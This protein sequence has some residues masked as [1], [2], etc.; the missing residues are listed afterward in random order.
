MLDT[1]TFESFAG[2]FPEPAQLTS[3]LIQ[4]YVLF[5]PMHDTCLYFRKMG[6]STAATADRKLSQIIR[7]RD[8]ITHDEF[9]AVE[10]WALIQYKDDILPV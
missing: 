8:K 4:V 7:G 6:L 2:L 3:P 10:T 5:Y 1:T 9:Q